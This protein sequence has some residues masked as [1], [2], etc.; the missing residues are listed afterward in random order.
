MDYRRLT[1]DSPAHCHRRGQNDT[2]CVDGLED[3]EEVAL[4]SDLFDEHRCQPLGAKLLVHAEV[5][6]LAA[7]QN[8]IKACQCDAG[9]GNTALLTFREP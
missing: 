5:I 4:S 6:D 3:A 2:G 7:L 1:Y 8:A 9:I